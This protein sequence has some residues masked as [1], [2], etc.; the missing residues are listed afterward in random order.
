MSSIDAACYEPWLRIAAAVAMVAVA[1][2]AHE[3]AQ[4]SERLDRPEQLSA[5]SGRA[6]APLSFPASRIGAGHAPALSAS[7]RTAVQAV[8]SASTAQDYGNLIV[9]FPQGL[10]SD[11]RG[12]MV[13]FYGDPRHPDGVIP[14]GGTTA[15]HVIGGVCNLYYRPS[16]GLE[17]SAPGDGSGCET[18]KDSAADITARRYGLGD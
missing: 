2:C 1:S 12:A 16:D 3:Q 9:S 13:L 18:W 7:Q 6:S 17:F 8:L 4:R 10:V 11:V 5:A 15:Y 14:R